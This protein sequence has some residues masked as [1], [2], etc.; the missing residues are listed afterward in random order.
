MSAISMK[1][2]QGGREVAARCDSANKKIMKTTR[3]FSRVF[4][5]QR[6][7][8]KNSLRKNFFAQKRGQNGLHHPPASSP[9][10]VDPAMANR[11]KLLVEGPLMQ[12]LPRAKPVVVS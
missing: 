6:S 8:R 2:R 7:L 1:Q 9:A 10:L 4:F 5:A 12:D 11:V 3:L